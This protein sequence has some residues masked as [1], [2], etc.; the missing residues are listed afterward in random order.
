MF[1]LMLLAVA[2][3]NED[4]EAQKALGARHF[5]R[6]G[7]EASADRHRWQV[8]FDDGEGSVRSDAGRV[9]TNL[10]DGRLIRFSGVRPVV[11]E[12]RRDVVWSSHEAAMA[13]LQAYGR[14]A[15]VPSEWKVTKET[16]S[17]DVVGPEN[18][19]KPG[20]ACVW[21]RQ[22]V[23]G[24]PTLN[25][26]NRA[27]L[28]ADPHTGKL[29]SFSMTYLVSHEGDKPVLSVEQGKQRAI[30]ALGKELD[31]AR[32]EALPKV[33]SVR[34]CY[35]LPQRDR[36]VDE[37]LSLSVTPRVARLAYEVVFAGTPDPRRPERIRHVTLVVDA[38]NGD[39]LSTSHHVEWPVRPRKASRSSRG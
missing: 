19:L 18:E 3:A 5:K 37:P 23:N 35:S 27:F 10:A 26:G 8:R 36:A 2:V 25:G 14:R 21:L 29:L 4:V 17:L 16:F 1:V 34:L 38:Q 7:V 33:E 20:R 13:G 22:M 6:L 39:T 28:E 9:A 24:L 11:A 32:L 12:P 31:V 30:E 15:N